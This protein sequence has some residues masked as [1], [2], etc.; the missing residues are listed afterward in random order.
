MNS[1]LWLLMAAFVCGINAAPSY[2]PLPVNPGGIGGL[3]R[4]PNQ[5]T[6]IRGP[7]GSEITSEQIGGAVQTEARLEPIV[8]P[9]QIAISS[10]TVSPSETISVSNNIEVASAT[11][12][13]TIPENSVPSLNLSPPVPIQTIPTDVS[14]RT[15]Q[16]AA[17]PTFVATAEEPHI[18]ETELVDAPEVEPNQS[19]DLEGPSGS[20]SVRGSSSIVSGPAS[21]TI[22]EPVRRIPVAPIPVAAPPVA[23]PSSVLIPPS[24]TAIDGFHPNVAQPYNTNLALPSIQNHRIPLTYNVQQSPPHLYT[25]LIPPPPPNG[26]VSR[27]QTVDAPLVEPQTQTVSSSPISP[28]SLPPNAIDL[29]QTVVTTTQRS[30]VA[31]SNGDIDVSRINLGQTVAQQ[32]IDNSLVNSR[33]QSSSTITPLGEQRIISSTSSPILSSSVQTPQITEENGDITQFSRPLFTTASKN[34]YLRADIPSSSS[35]SNSNSIFTPN[36]LTGSIPLQDQSILANQI[37]SNAPNAAGG[38][39]ATGVQEGNN[40]P[41]RSW[42]NI[43]D[44]HILP[45]TVT[46]PLNGGQ[47]STVL[48][49]VLVQPTDPRNREVIEFGGKQLENVG[50]IVP[51]IHHPVLVA[52]GLTQLQQIPTASI[53]QLTSR[54]DLDTNDYG[55]YGRQTESKN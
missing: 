8:V 25:E 34:T 35:L 11:P 14:I 12:V 48:D 52:G 53:S 6:I 23:V 3:F 7:D 51:V 47:I 36:G 33:I 1:V 16:S 55:R 30:T 40:V 22:S 41:S 37:V 49:T 38:L 50:N 44:G 17:L 13:V 4:G 21:T 19:S 15:E 31:P 43:D 2:P 9:D 10:V 39:I 5:E 45:S 29:G 27:L 54:N 20:I 28:Q 18:I 46:P 26:E 32:N 42:V 24:P